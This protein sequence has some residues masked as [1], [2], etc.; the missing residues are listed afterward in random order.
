MAGLGGKFSCNNISEI[1]GGIKFISDA[2]SGS[3]PDIRLVQIGGLLDGGNM[4]SLEAFNIVN[5]PAASGVVV[6]TVAVV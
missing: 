2:K 1:L 5:V 6:D 4:L 3:V